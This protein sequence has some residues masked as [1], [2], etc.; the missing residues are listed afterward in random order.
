MVKIYTCEKCGK[1][2]KQKGHYTKHLQRKTPCDN[3]VD[4]KIEKIVEEKVNKVVDEKIQ[5]LLENKNLI[6]NIDDNSSKE[7]EKYNFIEVCSGGGGL[8]CGLIKSGLNA[9]LLNDIDKNS[10]QTLRI[11]H[12][13]IKVHEGSFIDID[14]SNR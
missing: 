4:S 7:M 11:N 8:S 13:D 5:E 1:T 3:I 9:I 14:Y 2:F 12:P 6:N 10:C